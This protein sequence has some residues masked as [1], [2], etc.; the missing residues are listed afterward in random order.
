VFHS[1]IKKKTIYLFGILVIFLLSIASTKEQHSSK[2][3]WHNC[4]RE[5]I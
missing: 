4:D 2:W 3:T 5:K 1:I